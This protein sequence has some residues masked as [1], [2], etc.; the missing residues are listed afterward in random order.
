MPARTPSPVPHPTAG[1]DGGT[2]AGRGTRWPVPQSTHAAG[3]R[4]GATAPQPCASHEDGGTGGAG[5]PSELGES[6]GGRAEGTHRARGRCSPE[7]N[8]RAGAGVWQGETCAA[9]EGGG[10]RRCGGTPQTQR[11]ASGG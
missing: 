4:A 11:P 6:Q 8:R 2:P 10:T 1:C 9:W 5:P 3:G 7:G